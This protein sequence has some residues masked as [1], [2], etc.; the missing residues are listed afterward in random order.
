[1][2]RRGESR[3]WSN[4]SSV[5]TTSSSYRGLRRRD[6]GACARRRRHARHREC[7]PH[8]TRARPPNRR[9]GARVAHWVTMSAD[10]LAGIARHGYEVVAFDYRGYGVS[11]GHPSE[12]GL[13]S[14]VDAIVRHAS[15]SHPPSLPIVYWGR[16]L[17]AA[18]A[19][20]AS[21]LKRPDAL[22][23]ESGFPDAR[24]LVRSSPP[25]AF[26]ALFS[27]YRFPVLERAN[28][29]GAPVLVMHGTA[30]SVIP[31]E[32][33]RALYDGLAG[34]KTFV[35]IAGG[36]HND[37]RPPDE[38]AYWRAVDDFIATTAR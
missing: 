1:M 14:D 4:Q 21:T 35:E 34:K 7:R 15:A 38:P 23:L 19:A 16:S 36:D 33:G 8:D 29:G 11:T 18:M 30:D 20:Y 27:T 22:I 10:V 28:A 25:L 13:Y 5:G 37:A 31:F 26:L 32:L 3:V 24:S 6:C 2:D 9:L 17:G 12:S